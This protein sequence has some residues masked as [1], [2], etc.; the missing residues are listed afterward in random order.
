M[1]LSL[2][3]LCGIS[4]AQQAKAPAAGPATQQFHKLYDQLEQVSKK[5]HALGKEC[6]SATP[7]RKKEIQAEGQ[8][9]AERLQKY[10]E[11]LFAA[12]KAAFKEAPNK[13]P[14]VRDL[15][16]NQVFMLID[17]DDYEKALTEADFLIRSGMSSK[18]LYEMLAYA[19]YNSNKFTYAEQAIKFAK[20]M[21]AQELK[22]AKAQGVSEA[23]IA[24]KRIGQNFP[25]IAAI[26]PSISDYKTAWAKEKELRAA[27]AQ[28]KDCPMVKLETTAG[29]ITLELFAN[30]APNTVANFVELVN[31]GFYDNLTFHRVMQGFMAQGGDPKGDGTGGPGYCIPCEVDNPGARQHFRGSLSMAHAGKDTGGSQFFITFVPTPHLDGKHTVFGRVAAGMDVLAKITREPNAQIPGMEPTVIKKATV[32]YMPS[33]PLPAVKKLPG[34]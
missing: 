23:D 20:K 27:N 19:A 7:E 1:A 24:K 22:D 33:K 14:E 30:E 4:M 21:A 9:L 11:P 5:F 10:K 32:I 15:L 25:A 13:D 2:V 8:A 34:K 6:Q 18:S 12:A 17:Y 28:N 3:M 29:D 26:E 16:L 31:K